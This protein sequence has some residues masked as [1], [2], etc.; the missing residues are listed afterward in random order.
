[1]AGGKARQILFR[2]FY[3]TS[4]TFVFILLVI[5]TAV[6]PADSI[7][8]SY[9]RNRL[10][11]IFLVA[12]VYVFTG[13]ASILV[14]A[15]RMYTNR[16]VLRDIPKTFMPIEKEDLPGKRVHRL[17]AETLERTAVIAYQARPRA[18]RIEHETVTAG[19]RMLALTKTKTAT[20]DTIEPSWGTVAHPGWSSPA[21]KE[22]PGLE[23]VTVVDELVDLI[24]A[25]AVSLVPGDPA[26]EP[27]EDVTLLPDPRVI[28]EIART[29]NMGMR[30]YLAHLIAV[31]V[32]PENSLSVAFL[33]AYERARF[34]SVPMTDND[35][36]ALMR[37]F[38]EILRSMQPVDINMLDLDDDSSGYESDQSSHQ[39]AASSL[40]NGKPLLPE[41][42]NDDTRSLPSTFS[43]SGS[44]RHHGVPPRR[45]SEDSAPSMTSY[46]QEQDHHI[47]DDRASFSRSRVEPDSSS[48]RDNE[49]NS[50]TSVQSLHTAPA[51]RT[52]S[53]PR[54][55]PTRRSRGRMY[56]AVSRFPT[57][58]SHPSMSND[59]LPIS[60]RSVSDTGSIVHHEIDAPG[61]AVS[62]TSSRSTGDRA[63]GRKP[64]VVRLATED[65]ERDGGSPYR[66]VTPA[67]EP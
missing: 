38:A 48:L 3:S 67:L 55:P 26:I 25:K 5:F 15:S 7:Y 23:Y 22:L 9:K 43:A 41:R 60:T 1:M 63:R 28:A 32:V 50:N 49:T 36:H 62:R 65:E 14:Y 29:G 17:I 35:F 59:S 46:E 61:P 54:P 52:P 10:I 42:T 40:V 45:I 4:F 31:A 44:V 58:S 33:A 12:G 66:I 57:R 24:E 6:T 2:I 37:M 13:L 21:N 18:R 19:A 16:S 30:S 34:S 8:E 64:G 56:S 39:Y 20:D 51:P 47:H 27:A 11:D 53:R